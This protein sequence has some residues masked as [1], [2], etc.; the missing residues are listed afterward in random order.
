MTP[1]PPAPGPVWAK[2]VGDRAHAANVRYCAGRDVAPR[3]PADSLLLDADLWTNRA[4]AVMLA[5][6]GILTPPQAAAILRALQDIADRAQRGEFPIPPDAEDVHMAVEAEVTRLAGPGS[7][8][9]L[10]AGRS[11]NDQT[12]TDCRLW[13][14][15]ALLDLGNAVAELIAGLVEHA[16]SHVSTV[17]PGFTHMQPAMVTTWGHV[18][19]AWAQGLLRDLERLEAAYRVVN[20]S[21]LGAAAAFGTSWPI[22]REL[23]AR[24]LGFDSVQENTLDCISSR[25]EAETQ[26]VAALAMLLNRL[27]GIGQDLIL[28]STPPRAW[29]RID[30]RF[31]TGSSIMPQKRNPDFAEVTRARAAVVAGTA[32]SLL[33]IG[34]AAPAG[35]N[36][37][38]Q[39]TKYLALDAFA[40][41]EDAPAI[42]LGVFETLQ[43]DAEAMRTAC[44]TGF[45]NAAEVAEALAAAARIPFRACYKLVAEAVARDE[46][47]GRLTRNTI[48]ALL[49]ERWKELVAE[50]GKESAAGEPTPARKAAQAKKTAGSADGSSGGGEVSLDPAHPF[51]FDAELWSTLDD[52]LALIQHRDQLGSPHP[53]RLQQALEALRT[54][55]AAARQRIES[56]QRTLTQAREML[57][58]EIRKTSA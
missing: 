6:Q 2:R 36:R 25:G 40:E 24:L 29:I 31:V 41:I 1:S 15:G 7:G 49:A 17:C 13:T 38:T 48:N 23:T 8:G 20:R 46:T 26:A 28:L 56:R 21:P 39:W 16:A 3:P 42:F 57:E 34:R 51:Q 43:V 22:D 54:D 14:R 9:W 55:T 37:D 5:R 44:E 12:T 27:S 35:Y 32:A 50:I 33:S 4:H 45:M 58:N 52:P 47:Q 30:D 11:R 18:V 53:R 19:A 10:H